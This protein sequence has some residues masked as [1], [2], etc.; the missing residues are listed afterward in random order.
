MSILLFLRKEVAMENDKNLFI[1][2]TKQQQQRKAIYVKTKYLSLL[3]LY[4]S[5]PHKKLPK[6]CEY[7]TSTYDFSCDENSYEASDSSAS[8]TQQWTDES[9]DRAG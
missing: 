7:T 1:F 8:S 5:L 9:Q 4:V 3:T 2:T 6:L